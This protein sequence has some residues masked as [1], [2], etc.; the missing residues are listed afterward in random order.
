[1][2][3][4]FNPNQLSP[5][6]LDERVKKFFTSMKEHKMTKRYFVTRTKMNTLPQWFV[7]ASRGKRRWIEHLHT[8]V[9]YENQLVGDI[10]VHSDFI[11]DDS[12]VDGFVAFA[13]S[14]NTNRK[15]W[16][17]FSPN[18]RTMNLVFRNM[19]GDVMTIDDGDFV[20]EFLLI[21]DD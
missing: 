8:R 2:P 19:G 9:R 16:E 14:Y 10:T 7:N 5:V 13:N 3:S 17:I 21:V 15:K 20:S 18:L 1:M 6:C 11:T 12:H 4:V